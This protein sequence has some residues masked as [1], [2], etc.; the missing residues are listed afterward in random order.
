MYCTVGAPSPLPLR[1]R[2][3]STHGLLQS[4]GHHGCFLSMHLRQCCPA[5]SSAAPGSPSWRAHRSSCLNLP[6]LRQPAHP[7]CSA[8]AA[9]A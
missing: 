1:T 4:S 3:T 2:C 7:R 9:S 8:R 5:H 6:L